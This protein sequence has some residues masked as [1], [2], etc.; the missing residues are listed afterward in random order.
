MVGSVVQMVVASL[1]TDIAPVQMVVTSLHT[2]IAP[3]QMVVAASPISHPRV[4]L[5]GSYRKSRDH[6]SY[7]TRSRVNR[8]VLSYQKV[9]A[10]QCHLLA[11]AHQEREFIV[12]RYNSCSSSRW[13]RERC[14]G[15]SVASWLDAE[16]IQKVLFLFR[17]SP[18]ASACGCRYSRERALGYPPPP[19]AAPAHRQA[20]KEQNQKAAFGGKKSPA[21]AGT[22][23][24]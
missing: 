18:Y 11:S 21:C 10:R 12:E 20:E 17:A 19:T 22:K 24:D 7:V 15:F 2:N 1:H 3:V 5:A 6:V 16:M 13:G 8:H 23:S 9:R 4:H 14:I